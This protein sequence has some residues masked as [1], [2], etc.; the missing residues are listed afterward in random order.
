MTRRLAPLVLLTLLAGPVAQAQDRLTPGFWI[1]PQE[2]GL[3]DETLTALCQHGMSLVLEDGSAV[4]YL[5]EVETGVDRLVIDSERVCAIAD[6][7]SACTTRLYSDTGFQDF[8]ATTEVLR[9]EQGHL[10]SRSTNLATGAVNR[11]YP[12]MCPPVAV[13]DFMVGWLAPRPP[14]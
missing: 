3:S 8:P 11:S 9:D 2:P 6:G 1:F 4:S 5:A 14:G 7:F 13:R 12:Q 10:G